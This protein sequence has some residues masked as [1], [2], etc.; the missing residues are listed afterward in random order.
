MQQ[1]RRGSA[2]ARLF[3]GSVSIALTLGSLKLIRHHPVDLESRDRATPVSVLLFPAL[4]PAR[5]LPAE[6]LPIRPERTA[7]T[8]SAVPA[9]RAPSP[10]Q[11][12]PHPAPVRSVSESPQRAPAE[13]SQARGPLRLDTQAIRR[14]L[15]GTGGAVREL[16]RN[17]GAELDSLRPNRAEQLSAAIAETAVAGCLAPNAGGS[18]LSLPIIAYLAIRGKCK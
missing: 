6:A 11:S 4:P 15:A 16:A 14:A 1:W 18:L 3:A 7:R 8:G 2:T 12:A 10:S 9:N 5:P 13:A 17:S